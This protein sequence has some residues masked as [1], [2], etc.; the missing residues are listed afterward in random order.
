MPQFILKIDLGNKGMLNL[1]G[2]ATALRYTAIE[3]DKRH[4]KQDYIRDINGNTAGRY[5]VIP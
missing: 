3:I 2:V 5:E 4:F 1:D